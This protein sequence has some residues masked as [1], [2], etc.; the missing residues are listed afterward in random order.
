MLFKLIETTYNSEWEYL[1]RDTFNLEVR[2]K[3][4]ATEVG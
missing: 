1:S 4:E 2:R 3:E